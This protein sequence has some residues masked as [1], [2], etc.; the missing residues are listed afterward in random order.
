MSLQENQLAILIPAYNEEDRIR[1]TL[2]EYLN[3]FKQSEIREFL[4]LVIL[5]GCRDNT[6]SVVQSFQSSTQAENVK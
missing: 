5:N 6:S 1:P 2:E 4:I 3:Y